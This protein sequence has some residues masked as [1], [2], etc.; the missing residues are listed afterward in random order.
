VVPD[1]GT[2]ALVGLTGKMD[3]INEGKEHKYVFEYSMPEQ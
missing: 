2:G 3:I 1:S